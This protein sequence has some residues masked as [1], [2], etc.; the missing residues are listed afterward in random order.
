[1]V[2]HLLSTRRKILTNFGATWKKLGESPK[3]EKHKS[4]SNRTSDKFSEVKKKGKK[5]KNIQLRNVFY[6]ER[7]ADQITE[8]ITEEQSGVKKKSK[9]FS[10]T[11]LLL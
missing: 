5:R 11:I 7:T 3:T 2:H 8:P 6:E 1:M 4:K 10:N 9:T